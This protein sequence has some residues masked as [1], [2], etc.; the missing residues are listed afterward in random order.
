MYI[1]D[2]NNFKI[3]A[4]KVAY[5]KNLKITKYTKLNLINLILS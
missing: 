2:F 1:Y 5:K 4:I 3:S